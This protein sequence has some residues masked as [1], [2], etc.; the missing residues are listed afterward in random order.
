MVSG[1]TPALTMTQFLLSLG[2]IVG[3]VVATGGVLYS[4]LHDDIKGVKT[5][6]ESVQTQLG[7]VRSD[8]TGMAVSINGLTN[9]M[10]KYQT[11]TDWDPQVLA[12]VLKK[13]GFKEQNI[14]I[15]SPR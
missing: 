10:D 11:Q 13:E 3:A 8:L 12:E 1:D 15:I 2:A 5:A 4:V 6:I 14:V 9:K 7:A